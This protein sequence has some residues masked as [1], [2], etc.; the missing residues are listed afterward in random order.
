M[1]ST[2]PTGFRLSPVY[3]VL[4]V[5]VLLGLWA[6]VAYNNMVTQKQNVETQWAQVE[7]TYQRRL[8]LVPNLVNTV[9]GAAN[10]EQTTLQAVTEARTKW[11]QPGASRDDKIAAA[12][13]FESSLS[14]LLV[15]VESYPQLKATQ[16]FSDLMTQLE[17][18]E[19][20]IAVAR[21]D[22]NDA[23][24]GYNLAVMRFPG[25]L[26]ARIFGFAPQ[27]FFQAAAGADTA[28]TVNFAQ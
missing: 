9:K 2:A 27:Q 14:R 18:T 17:G 3:I 16:A 13:Q 6:I 23:V 4:G 26:F 10:F 5:I 8:D 24:R 25:S 15:T 28:P 19:N 12:D 1:N 11:M 20:R 7:T 22:Y 21:R